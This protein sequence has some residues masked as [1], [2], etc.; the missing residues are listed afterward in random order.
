MTVDKVHVLATLGLD[1]HGAYVALSRHRDSVD[2][3]YGADDFADRDRLVRTLGRERGKNMVA[4][5]KQGACRRC[6]HASQ[7]P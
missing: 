6:A 7:Q 5:Y 4:D 2:L 1:R 3:H